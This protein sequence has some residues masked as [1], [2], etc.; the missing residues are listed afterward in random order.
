MMIFWRRFCVISAL[1]ILL[2]SPTFANMKKGSVGNG[3]QKTF[4]FSTTQDGPCSV[5]IIYDSNTADLDTGIG[6]AA[7]GDTVC[8][9]ISTQNNSDACTA[10]LPPGDYFI[11]VI[12]FKGSSN[13]RTLVNCGSQ[14][15]IVTGREAGSGVT[16]KEFEGNSKSRK[17]MEQLKKTAESTK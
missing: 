6:S 11:G 10:G 8:L 13:F 4:V 12:S 15:T 17:F 2:G 3:A 16:V 5:T 9:G 14:E 7:S 1:L